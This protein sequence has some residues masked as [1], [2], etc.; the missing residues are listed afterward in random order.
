MA[1]RLKSLA[2]WAGIVQSSRYDDDDEFAAP[3]VTDVVE[4]PEPEQVTEAVPSRQANVTS[5]EQH[6]RARGQATPAREAGPDEIAHIRPRSYT[7]DAA[8]IAEGYKEGVPVIMNMEDLDD[9]DAFR[10][11]DFAS[12]L[13]FAL[14]GTLEKI[15]SRVF[16]LTPPTVK[17]TARDKERV[18]MTT[19]VVAPGLVAQ[20]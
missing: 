9:T 6:R 7:S 19:G 1:S 8:R 12:G 14:D 16:L 4:E 20:A 17:V 5:I 10:L 3:E 2:E 15:T 13:R 18:A 11:I